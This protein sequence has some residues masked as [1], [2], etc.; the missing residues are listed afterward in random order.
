MKRFLS[1]DVLTIYS[2]LL[3]NQN[4][5]FHPFFSK[6]PGF[7]YELLH[8]HASVAAPESWDNTV[9]TMLVTAFCNFQIC[10]MSTCGQHTLTGNI[11]KKINALVLFKVSA[12]LGFLYSLADI[13]VRGCTKNSIHFRYFL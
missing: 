3:G 7:F 2:S 8:R 12:C 6:R 9:G 10:K 1:I 11:R 13:A 4:Q 5:L